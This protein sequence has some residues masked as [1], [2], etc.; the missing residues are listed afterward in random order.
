VGK[1]GKASAD[2]QDEYLSERLW[3]WSQMELD[4]AG[5]L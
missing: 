4:D 3:E 5:F 2:A 1:K